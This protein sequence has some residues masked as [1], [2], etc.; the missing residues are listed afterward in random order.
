MYRRRLERL[1][2][3]SPIL[4]RDALWFGRG[5]LIQGEDNFVYISLNYA[6]S[7]FSRLKSGM[8][9]RGF[10]ILNSYYPCPSQH[11]ILIVVPSD[12]ALTASRTKAVGAPCLHISGS[13][14]LLISL[15]S[16]VFKL[17]PSFWINRTESHKFAN[18]TDDRIVAWNSFQKFIRAGTFFRIIYVEQG[19]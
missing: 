12:L 2:G 11:V 16:L 1:W 3:F 8:R 17:S 18:V 13:F 14:W 4:T 15:F 7:K 10:V 9:S 6:I 19:M 5:F